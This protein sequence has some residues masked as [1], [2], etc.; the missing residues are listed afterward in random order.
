VDTPLNN[1]D[2]VRRHCI[3]EPFVHTVLMLD[4]SAN[5]TNDATQELATPAEPTV[6]LL[7]VRGVGENILNKCHF[8]LWW[9]QQTWCRGTFTPQGCP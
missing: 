8:S 5:Y 4:M 9:T 1:C 6:R 2:T 7:G 3:P